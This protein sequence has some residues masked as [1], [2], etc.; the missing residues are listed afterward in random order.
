MIDLKNITKTYGD[1][2][3]AFNALN[4]VNLKIDSGEFV[5][6]IG[7]SGSGKSTLLNIIG[8]MD[9]FN[10]GNYILDDKEIDIKNMKSKEL[11]KIRNNKFGFIFQNFALLDNYTVYENIEVPIAYRNRLE[12]SKLDRKSIK[13]KIIKLLKEF[14]LEDKKDKYPKELSGG[15]QQRVAIIR[16][17]VN[18]ADIILADEPT[19][20]LDSETGNFVFNE[21]KKIND[22]GRTVIIITHDEKIANK[23]KRIIRIVD[24]HIC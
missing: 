19:G 6:I 22:T 10:E 14:G 16:A 5:A 13:D 21:L 11:S 23:C 1:K 8:L 20:A 2:E 24:G 17:I 3:N 9:N 4:N 7:P 18:E 15:Q 12:K